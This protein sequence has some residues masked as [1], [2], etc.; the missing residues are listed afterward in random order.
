M[1]GSRDVFKK[2]GPRP[3]CYFALLCVATSVVLICAG[4]TFGQSATGT[5]T[6]T[7]TD[8]KGLAMASVK[9]LVHN[10]DTGVDE[11][12][13]VTTDTGVY[14]APLLPPG[15]YDILLRALNW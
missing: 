14:V 6:G 12:P 1:R 5:L 9:V 10:A 4:N 13:T 8:I 7:V 15:T 11:M 2:K 3:Y